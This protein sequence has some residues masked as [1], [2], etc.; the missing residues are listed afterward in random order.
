MTSP[1]KPPTPIE[2]KPARSVQQQPRVWH[3]SKKNK[4]AD[5]PTQRT[6]N[7]LQKEDT[8]PTWQSQQNSQSLIPPMPAPDHSQNQ[9]QTTPHINTE[10]ANKPHMTQN[11][12]PTQLQ[13]TSQ[14]KVS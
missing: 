11:G 8:R 2:E 14:H 13:S 1:K 5:Q 3:R 10:A 7:M 6:K 9:H 12:R 4:R